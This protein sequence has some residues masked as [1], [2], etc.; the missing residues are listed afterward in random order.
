MPAR[1]P[2]AHSKIAIRRRE[3]DL[4]GSFSQRGGQRGG[5]PRRRPFPVPGLAGL[6]PAP[7][8]D[9]VETAVPR[10]RLMVPRRP[11]EAELIATRSAGCGHRPLCG[12]ADTSAGWL[13]ADVEVDPGHEDH[14]ER[15]GGKAPAAR[16]GRSSRGQGS[17][18]TGK[19]R[20]ILVSE[21]GLEPPFVA[22]PLK[23][24]VHAVKLAATGSVSKSRHPQRCVD[25]GRHV[26]RG[27]FLVRPGVADG[28][29]VRCSRWR[30]R[31]CLGTGRRNATNPASP[32]GGPSRLGN[33][34]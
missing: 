27:Q 22:H 20:W 18:T 2:A 11:T 12:S 15:C 16:T 1:I 7:G 31:C 23:M 33:G 10:H 4:A 29:A 21:G 3:P 14:R 9:D 17:L 25:V 8:T 19:M 6:G 28:R 24:G 26:L 13:R 34:A 32:S 30:R 5:G